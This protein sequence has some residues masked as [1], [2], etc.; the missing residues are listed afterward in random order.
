MAGSVAGGVALSDSIHSPSVESASSEAAQFKNTF[1]L[2]EVSIDEIHRGLATGEY[3][4]RSLVEKYIA[5]IE[6]IDGKLN[7]VIEINPDAIQLA[8]EADAARVHADV[9]PMHGIPVL[10]KDNI[11]TADKM[12]TTAGSWALENAP[13]PPE[14]SFV[15]S[16]LRRAGAIILGKTNL[17]EWANIRSTASTSG[18]SGRGGQTNNPYALDRNPCGSSSGSG[19]ATSASLCAVAVGTETD[20]SIVC[21]SACCSLVGIKPT[22]GLVGRTGIIPI[23]HTQDTAGPMA[24]TV[25]DA[26]IL[27]G[28]LV[29]VDPQDSV[30]AKCKEHLPAYRDYTQFLEPGGL[31]GARIGVARNFMDFHAGVEKQME[32]VLEAMKSAGAELID[33]EDLSVTDEAGEAEGIVFEYELKHGMEAY[34][35]RLGA[36][37]PMKTLADLIKFNEDNRD[38]EMPYFG[39]EFFEKAVERGP[40]TEFRY[41]E[42]INKCRRLTRTEGIDAAMDKHKLDCFVA[43]TLS[44]PCRTDLVNGDHWLGFSTSPAA[45]SGY[46]SITVPGG[47][48]F[49]LPLGV[50][51]FGRAWSEATLLKLAFDFEQTTQYRQPPKF[52]ATVDLTPN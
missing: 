45:I 10:I 24:R 15:A 48:V 44:L 42:A 32:Q 39:Q 22:M 2:S 51:F 23:S 29:G 43:P 36:D 49:G 41:I 26:A 31:K 14:D 27:L 4:C 37:S 30:T 46:P 18:W 17:S 9:G 12:K 6:E 13:K 19:V 50:S 40:L 7:S 3:T 28:A 21:P 1:E 5:R 52:L 33:T 8:E 16:Q 35:A 11:D 20:G 34:L 25:K 38:R 47:Y